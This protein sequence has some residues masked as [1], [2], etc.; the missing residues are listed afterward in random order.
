LQKGIKANVLYK[1]FSVEFFAKNLS[2][3]NLKSIEINYKFITI[4][5]F[6]LFWKRWNIFSTYNSI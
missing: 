4:K 5:K 6:N 1:N 2:C 3:K